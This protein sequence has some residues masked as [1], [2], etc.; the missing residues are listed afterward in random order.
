MSN[1]PT[2]V[3]NRQ[4][5]FAKLVVEGM[6]NAQ[7]YRAIYNPAAH[8]RRAAEQG[9]KIAAMPLVKAEIARL[10]SL[11]TAKTLLTVNDQLGILAGIAQQ[12][13][14]TAS[15]Q[16]ARVRAVEVYAKIAGT[17]APERHEHSGP[18]GQP[19][20]VATALTGTVTATVT[21]LSVRERIRL[22]KETRERQLQEQA[23]PTPPT[24]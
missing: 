19:I 12:P 18:D 3:N 23:A 4:W 9:C 7:A 13:A 20:P 5:A 10:R 17:Q 2:K 24:S 22:L 16:N 14:R 8:D 21:R 11:S 15:E 6:S 1:K